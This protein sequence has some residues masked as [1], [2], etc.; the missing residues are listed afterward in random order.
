MDEDLHD[1]HPVQ[2]KRPARG[3][4]DMIAGQVEPPCSTNHP[5]QR[6]LP[7]RFAPPRKAEGAGESPSMDPGAA[8]APEVPTVDEAGVSRITR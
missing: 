6:P 4:P 2:G 5:P 8:S 1:A 3:Q 7:A